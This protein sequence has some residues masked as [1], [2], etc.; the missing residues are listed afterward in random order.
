[1]KQQKLTCNGYSLVVVCLAVEFPVLDEA[2]MY[3][4]TLTD[5]ALQAVFM[6]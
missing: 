4:R 3:K 2:G 1:M 6:P 5:T